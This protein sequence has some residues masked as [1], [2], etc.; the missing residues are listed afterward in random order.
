MVEQ[1]SVVRVG[2]KVLFLFL[3]SSSRHNLI[4]S[5]EPIPHS[6]APT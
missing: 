6:N 2:D 3:V 1:R 5:F 4:G